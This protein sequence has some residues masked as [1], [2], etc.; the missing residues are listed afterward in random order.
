MSKQ[1]A[2]SAEETKGE[3]GSLQSQMGD[4]CLRKLAQQHLKQVKAQVEAE[5]EQAL[6]QA[7][8]ALWS[9]K[10]F[11]DM[12]TEFL[13]GGQEESFVRARLRGLRTQFY[14]QASCD[15]NQHTDALEAIRVKP[16]EQVLVQEEL[17]WCQE[18]TQQK[19]GLLFLPRRFNIDSGAGQ[20]GESIM[21]P[22]E[23]LL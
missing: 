6:E 16:M 20:I 23:M 21:A 17:Y 2:I 7:E 8:L 14:S 12:Q 11:Q 5:F 9:Q 19:N 4:T 18:A 13:S 1:K 22:Q 3:L 10:A 15:V